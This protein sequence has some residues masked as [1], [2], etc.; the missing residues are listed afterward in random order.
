MRRASSSMMTSS[1]HL[2]SR[3]IGVDAPYPRMSGRTTRNRRASSGTHAYHARPLSQLPCRSTIVSG[4]V[5]GSVKS[6]PR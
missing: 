5:H 2:K 1:D 3:G 4:V 6:S